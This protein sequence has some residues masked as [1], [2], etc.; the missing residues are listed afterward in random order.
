MHGI[1]MRS[2][3]TLIP[4]ICV[5][6]YSGLLPPSRAMLC[7]RNSE[8]PTLQCVRSRIAHS[9]GRR[10]GNDASSICILLYSMRGFALSR[11]PH[12]AT[13]LLP[14][15]LGNPLAEIL[16]TPLESRALA[17]TVL[18]AA[19]CCLWHVMFAS[20]YYIDLPRFQTLRATPL[21]M[22]RNAST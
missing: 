13:P 10:P 15:L 2:N 11:T 18:A 9:G 20:R 6:S 5:A 19:M 7:V 4:C 21:E 12:E 8:F 22:Q 1:S 14:W 17:R 3:V 16:A